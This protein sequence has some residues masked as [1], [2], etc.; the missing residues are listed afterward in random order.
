MLPND[1]NKQMKKWKGSIN[2]AKQYWTYIIY[3]RGL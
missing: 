1:Q 3:S 2:I